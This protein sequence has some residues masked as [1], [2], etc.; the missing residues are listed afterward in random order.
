MSGAKKL[1]HNT[2][3]LTATSFLMRTIAVSFNVYLTDKIGTDGIGLFQL[4][5]SV[6]AMA[7]TFASG[8]IKLA[9]MRLVADNRVSS[10]LSERQIMRTCLFY[11]FAC[12]TIVAIILYEFSGFIGT[13]WIGDERSISSLKVLSLSLPFISASAALGGYFTAIGKVFRYTFVQLCEQLLK[14]T[15]TVFALRSV[16]S[17]GLEASCIA[18]V[19]GMTVTEIFSATA[20][21]VLYRITS[22]KSEFTDKL[23]NISKKLLHI[24]IPK[25]QFRG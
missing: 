17:Y 9:S 2:L 8:G 13:K 7:I 10:H 6:Y 18:I 14:I 12:G 5:S 3:L 4:I 22:E 23:K 1:L 11:A 15:V 21:A 16:V 19:S 25:P 24:A 20:S